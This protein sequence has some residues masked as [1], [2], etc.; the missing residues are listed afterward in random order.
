MKE[1]ANQLA[2]LIDAIRECETVRRVGRVEQFYGSVLECAGPDAFLGEVCEVF[3]PGQLTSIAAEVVGFR[4][5]RVL[6]MP[7]GRVTGIHVGSEVVATGLP[8]SVTVN[9]GMLGKVVNAFGTPLD[10]GV[11]SSPGKSYPLYREPINPMERAPCDEPLN[12]G[13]RVIDAFCAMAKGQRVGI[14]AG[15]GVGKSTL[16][17]MIAKQCDAEVNVIALIGERGREVSEFIQDN[18][19]SDGL[20]KSVVVAA[21][22]DEPALVRVH[23]A[24]VATAIAEYFK[25]KGKHVMLYMDS[26]TRL[27]TA[28]REIGLAIGEPPTSRGYTPSTFSLLPRLTERAGIFKSG[29]SISALYTVL[30]E[31][32]DFNEPVS[33]TVRSILDGHIMLKRQLAHQGIF[34]AIDIRESMSRLFPRVTG[35]EQQM[36][37]RELIRLESLYQESKELIE[38]G[39][40]KQGGDPEIDQA[41]RVHKALNKFI[42]QS[43]GESGSNRDI[44]TALKQVLSGK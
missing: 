11:L 19:G 4:H 3:S 23:A 42:S 36:A 29:G 26:I 21:T 9:D 34:P 14:F 10:G 32:D 6:L 2:R 20:K 35:K 1:N 15:S 24:F 40:Y 30:V 17:G 28:Q 13:V 5:G 41:I 33:D 16:L 43:E 38:L 37:V 31:G 27:A 8:A 25:D 18:L 7:L 44:V 39:A 12:L 22:A